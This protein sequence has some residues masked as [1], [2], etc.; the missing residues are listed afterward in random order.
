MQSILY[1][2]QWQLASFDFQ[3]KSLIELALCLVKENI[4]V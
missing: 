4:A 2:K 3:N 1:F